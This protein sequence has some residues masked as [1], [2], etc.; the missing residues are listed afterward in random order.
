M[1]ASYKTRYLHLSKILVSKGQKVS[2]G[3]RIGLSGSTGRVTGPHIHYELIDRGRAVNAMTANIP[4]A[5][6]VPKSEML[7]FKARRDELDIMLR[8]QEIQLAGHAA[9][10]PT[11]G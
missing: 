3:Q 4:M 7:A 9:S 8:Q 6:S 5:S 11:A 2:R 1:E 10:E